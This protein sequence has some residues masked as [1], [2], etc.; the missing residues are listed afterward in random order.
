MP[1][2]YQ[3]RTTDDSVIIIK[4]TTGYKDFLS[5]KKVRKGNIKEYTLTNPLA[6]SCLDYLYDNNMD[7]IIKSFNQ[8]Y[9]VVKNFRFI[10]SGQSVGG[11]WW[12][13][14]IRYYPFQDFF[15]KI[16]KWYKYSA[17]DWQ[18]FALILEEVQQHWRFLKESEVAKNIKYTSNKK[19]VKYSRNIRTKYQGVKNLLQ[20]INNMYENW[21]EEWLVK[22]DSKV[23]TI[24]AIELYKQLDK[25]KMLKHIKKNKE[26]NI[27]DI[28]NFYPIKL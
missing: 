12:C 28:I 27:Y 24:M 23:N 2:K 18:T 1:Y 15:C 8:E 25:E 13:R 19:K 10:R 7:Y 3:A 26:K 4:S 9:I 16:I 14:W 6:I 22:M 5:N 11:L 21:D 20:T 17:I